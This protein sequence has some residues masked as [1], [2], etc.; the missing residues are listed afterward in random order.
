[1]N[2]KGPGDAGT[3]WLSVMVA[4]ITPVLFW[5]RDAKGEAAI[6]LSEQRF[7]STTTPGAPWANG[8]NP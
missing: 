4:V 5:R 2:I 8:N 1:M 6:G 7:L 3:A